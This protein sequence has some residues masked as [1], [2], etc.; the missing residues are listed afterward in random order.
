MA[1]V[2]F[3]AGKI[4]AHIAKAF[5]PDQ[6]EDLV[7][8]LVGGFPVV[9]FR[10]KVWRVIKGAESNLITAPGTDDP[11]PSLEVVILKSYKHLS[12]IYYEK[13]YEEGDDASPDCFSVDGIRPDPSV[14]SPQDVTCA[15]C[16]N[17]VWGSKITPQ[18]K[19]TRACADARRLA[20]IAAGDL[21]KA[22]Y[23]PMLLR[24]PPASLAEL[25][26][27]AKVL[28]TRKVPYFGVVTKL[29]FDSQASFP[30]LT[31]KPSRFLDD[32]EYAK[33]HE[34]LKD[35]LVTRIIGETTETFVPRETPPPAA[36][37]PAPKVVVEKSAPNPPEPEKK[38]P[39]PAATPSL[40]T[41]LDEALASLDG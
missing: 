18:G 25:E 28:S 13:A 16:K 22:I 33:V 20:V 12:K 14:Q 36:A 3:E 15:V 41:S 29:G 8:G 38:A 17:N 10:G 26:A 37:K 34:L 27:F 2:P 21:D 1:I 24:V 32:S 23:G 6:T 30:R 40:M 31:F 35:E 9:S 19:K 5:N 7:G 39:A 11:A 4:P